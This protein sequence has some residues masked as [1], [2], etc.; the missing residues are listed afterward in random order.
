MLRKVLLPTAVPGN[1]FLHS[2]PGRREPLAAVWRATKAVAI[3][4]IV[5]LAPPSEMRAK[6]P[7]YADA[8][9]GGS[10]PGR[11][12]TF[13]IPDFGVPVDRNA[14]VSFAA[15]IAGQ[16]QSGDSVLVHCGAGIGR[17]GTFAACVLMAL[18]MNPEAARDAVETAGSAPETSEQQELVTWCAS[19]GRDRA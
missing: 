17:T 15:E 10:V 19:Q 9:N 14:F 8:L 6:S 3:D 13:E 1:L 16:L 12:R 11:V 4:T 2:M 7:E 18:G 5:C